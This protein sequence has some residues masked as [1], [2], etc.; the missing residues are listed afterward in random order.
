MLTA[1]VGGVEVEC[2]PQWQLSKHRSGGRETATAQLGNWGRR[3]EGVR[4]QH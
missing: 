1:A 3:G 2:R 4:P